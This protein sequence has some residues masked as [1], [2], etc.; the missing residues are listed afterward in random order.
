[1]LQVLKVMLVH[2]VT[3]DHKGLQV[4]Q[5]HKDMLVHKEL[6]EAREIRVI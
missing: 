1:M 4:Q 2:K 6:Q 5:V 3:L